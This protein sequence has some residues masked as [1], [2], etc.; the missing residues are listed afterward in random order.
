MKDA[1]ILGAIIARVATMVLLGFGSLLMLAFSPLVSV[2]MVIG[3][4]LLSLD[5]SGTPDKAEERLPANTKGRKVMAI[6][7]AIIAAGIWTLPYVL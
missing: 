7:L 2:A 5:W 4:F 6:I 3:L 1:I